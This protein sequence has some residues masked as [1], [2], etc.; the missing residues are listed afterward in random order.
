MAREAAAV[1]GSEATLFFQSLDEGGAEMWSRWDMQ[2]HPP[3]LLITNY[4]M[5]NIMLM[6]SFEAGI[7]DQ[8]RAWIATD[9]SHVFHLVVDEL[10]TYRGMPGTEVAYLLR[11]LLDRLGLTPDSE[12]LRIIAASASLESGSNG[13]KYLQSFFGRDRSRFTVVGGTTTPPNPAALSVCATFA[14][15]FRDFGCAVQDNTD[16]LTEPT[17]ALAEAVGVNPADGESSRVLREVVLRSMAGEALRVACQINLLPQ[18][19]VGTSQMFVFKDECPSLDS[20][21]SFLT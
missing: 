10:H 6:R 9:R 7:F 21:V 2:D 11:V 13:L 4:S 1:A 5:L 14:S 3:D 8:T 12:Q 19:T 20:H 16:N 18:M 17:R 15:A